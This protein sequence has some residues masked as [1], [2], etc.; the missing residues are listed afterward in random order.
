MKDIKWNRGL[1]RIWIVLS[2]L[3]IIAWIFDVLPYYENWESS[4]LYSLIAPLIVLIV[5][6][7]VQKII[8]FIIT[9]FKK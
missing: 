4:I 5:F 3:W 2:T 8:K 9:G 6:L 1:F 7:V